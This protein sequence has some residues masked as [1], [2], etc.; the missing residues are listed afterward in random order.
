[1]KFDHRLGNGHHARSILAA[2][3]RHAP[4]GPLEPWLEGLGFRLILETI[5]PS[6]TD[7]QR[8]GF[9]WLLGEWLKLDPGAA[10]NMEQLKSQVLIATFGA[11]KITDPHGNELLMPVKRT[12]QEWDWDSVSY[13]KKAMTREQYT[14][15][16]ESAYR[17]GPKDLPE[18]ER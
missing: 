10:K 17:L 15:L 4:L 5:K 2:I 12:T 9:H 18:M 11:V 14:Q 7:E 3:G 1:M 6:H 8:Q 13:K 16:I